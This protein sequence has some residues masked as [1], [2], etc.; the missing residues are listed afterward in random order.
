MDKKVWKNRN[1]YK[2]ITINFQMSGMT[3]KTSGV[4]GNTRV[5]AYVVRSY[6]FDGQ[7]ADSFIKIRYINT[8]MPISQGLVI[9]RP[10]NCDGLISFDDCTLNS[11]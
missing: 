7:R 8:K 1:R 5:F 9:K 2:T 11:D 3:N 6:R 10:R 4:I